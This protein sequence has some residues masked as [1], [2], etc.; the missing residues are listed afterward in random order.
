MTGPSL[1]PVPASAASAASGGRGD[2][3]RAEEKE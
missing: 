1:D 3:R 2:G